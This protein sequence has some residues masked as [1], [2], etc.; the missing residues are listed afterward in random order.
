LINQPKASCHLAGTFAEHGVELK[1]VDKGRAIATVVDHLA[2][3][4][5]NKSV[6][7]H[8]YTILNQVSTATLD[9]QG[10]GLL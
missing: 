1:A 9:M 7:L 2:Q 3:F 8:I 5:K 6:P 4:K 10:V